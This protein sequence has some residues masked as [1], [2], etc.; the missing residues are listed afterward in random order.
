MTFFTSSSSSISGTARLTGLKGS[1]GRVVSLAVVE[2]KEKATVELL[3]TKGWAP[4]LESAL[5]RVER[6]A[7]RNGPTLRAVLETAG[8]KPCKQ[9]KSKAA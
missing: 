7:V 6:S 9:G 2:E 8:T 3:A 5:V 1:F 4:R